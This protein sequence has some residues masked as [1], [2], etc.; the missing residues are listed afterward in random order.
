M[1][2]R[3]DLFI[4]VGE[5]IVIKAEEAQ[6]RGFLKQCT[7]QLEDLVTLELDQLR[8]DVLA[9]DFSSFTQIM[10]GKSSTNRIFDAVLFRKQIGKQ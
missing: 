7:K 10:H 1:E 2:Q 8:N 4:S 5:P 9:T 3:P 6:A